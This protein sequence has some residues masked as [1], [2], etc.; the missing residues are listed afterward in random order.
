M[1]K[2]MRFWTS[3]CLILCGCFFLRTG[4]FGSNLPYL[5]LVLNLIGGPLL[6]GGFCIIYVVYLHEKD[7]DY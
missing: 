5:R 1:F 2:D 4:T 3:L 7:K 6:C